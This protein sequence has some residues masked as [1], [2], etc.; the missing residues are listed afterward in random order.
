MLE[1]KKDTVGTAAVVG[2]KRYEGRST[3]SKRRADAK[4]GAAV[5]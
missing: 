4:K 3:V 1:M 2:K 5:R